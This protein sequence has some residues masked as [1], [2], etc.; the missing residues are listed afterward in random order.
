MPDG[1]EERGASSSSLRSIAPL[2][3]AAFL[4]FSAGDALRPA[5][6]QALARTAIGLIDSYRAA[7]S[8]ALGFLG[9]ARCLYRPTCSAYGREA[10]RRYGFPRGTWLAAGRI[11]RCNPFRKGGEDPVP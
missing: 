2:V 11:L 7:V 6:D 5:P 3:L 10:I 9:L 8:P 1:P 4:G